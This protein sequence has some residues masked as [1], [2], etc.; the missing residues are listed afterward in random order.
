M[1]TKLNFYGEKNNFWTTRVLNLKWKFPPT[2]SVIVN[3]NIIEYNIMLV[4]VDA[5]INTRVSCFCIDYFR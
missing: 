3:L 1:I 2:I 4:L 5:N